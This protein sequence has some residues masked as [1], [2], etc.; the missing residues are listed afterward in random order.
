[1][2]KHGKVLRF[3]KV[4][5]YAH[6][7]YVIFYLLLALTGI[8]IYLDLFDFLLPLLGGSQ[9]ARLIHRVAAV[10]FVVG[11][12][13]AIM[14][15]PTGFRQWMKEIFT[16]N[17]NDIKFL[18]GFAKEMMGGHVNLPPQGRFNAGEKVNSLLQI[19]GG[20][21]LVLSGLV[22]LMPEWFPKAMVLVSY[23]L[24]DLAFVL[25]FTA[26]LGHA[27]M[28]LFNPSTKEAING[29]TSGYIDEKFAES[30]YT[31]WYEELKKSGQVK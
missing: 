8:M 31:L 18:G 28:A 2:A 26:F 11:P 27:Y 6:W 23:P 19:G 13:V 21:L 22:M 30:H 10:V 1:M 24:H 15:N 17:K 14:A 12:L 5:I 16:W 7:I 20:I 9:G 3:G 25:T 4:A 29:M